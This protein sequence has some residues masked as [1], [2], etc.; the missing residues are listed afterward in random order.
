MCHNESLCIR[1]LPALSALAAA[2]G[3]LLPLPCGSH[4]CTLDGRGGA[5]SRTL[6]AALL[7]LTY[8][9]DLQHCS[10]L[11]DFGCSVNSVHLVHLRRPGQGL[12]SCC[13]CWRWQ[14]CCLCCCLRFQ[15]SGVRC[16]VAAAAT[17]R[18]RRCYLCCCLRFQWSG[19][20]CCFAAA[21]NGQH[22]R[23]VFLC[24]SCTNSKLQSLE[25]LT[26][27]HLSINLTCHGDLLS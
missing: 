24:R 23:R 10:T 16:C 9:T 25:S 19:A 26:L 27:Q 22:R 4:P 6:K 3:L 21:A 17:G 11:S 7:A 13:C 5:A 15:W 20:R 18:H 1:T 14:W 12:G 8:A 2:T